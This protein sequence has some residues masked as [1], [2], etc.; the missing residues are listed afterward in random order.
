MKKGFL[1]LIGVLLV[2]SFVFMGCDPDPK[3]ED[4]TTKF[5]GTWVMEVNSVSATYKFTNNNF[6]FSSNDTTEQ[7]FAKGPFSGTFE[8]TETTITFTTTDKTWTLDYAFQNGML[9]LSNSQGDNPTKL[10]NGT[11]T[12]Q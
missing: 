3:E 2:F 6:V 10:G 5:E 12:K 7:Y 1:A 8:F 4:Q 9:S 11:L